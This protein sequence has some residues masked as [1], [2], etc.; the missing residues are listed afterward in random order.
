MVGGKKTKRQTGIYRRKPGLW[1]CSWDGEPAVSSIVSRDG[2]SVEMWDPVRR[3]TTSTNVLNHSVSFVEY[4][5][6]PLEYLQ[7][8]GS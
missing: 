3:V 7:G 4:F 5:G 2:R 6:S 1:R 8:I